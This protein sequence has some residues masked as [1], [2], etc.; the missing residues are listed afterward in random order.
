M[1][2]TFFMNKETGEL[3]TYA[4]MQEQFI[5]DYDGNDETNILSYYEYYLR[6]DGKNNE[7]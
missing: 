3:L 2:E 7:K 6:I 5:Q 4:E 1:K